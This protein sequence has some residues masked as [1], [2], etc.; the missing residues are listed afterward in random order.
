MPEE[1]NRVLT[2]RLSDLLFTTS[3]D[4]D[5]NLKTEGISGDRIFFVGNVMIDTL[6]KH[7]KRSES[8]RIL[9]DLSLKSGEY[10]VLTLHRPANVDDRASLAHLFSILEDVQKKIPVVY[11]I[12]P[13]AKKMI[14]EA[15]LSKELDGMQ[16]L[17][18][19]DPLGYL[20]FIHLMKHATFVMTDS[21]GIQEETTILGIPCLTLRQETERPVTI[22]QGTNTL[23]KT[24]RA[25]ILDA[26]DK[27]QTGRI[28]KGRIPEKWDGKAASRI[29]S[30][31][32]DRFS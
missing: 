16:N 6:L 26:V 7:L 10:S 32:S 14:K 20:D 15:G 22:T 11:P 30:F 29:V 18:F 3:R 24:D 4:A 25:K 13:R 5:E 27:A 9:D 28:E 17:L 31:I 2:D 12:H 1:I 19:V 23:V 8:S 21:G